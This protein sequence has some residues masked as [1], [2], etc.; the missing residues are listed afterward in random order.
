MGNIHSACQM[1]NHSHRNVRVFITEKAVEIDGFVTSEPGGD[2]KISPTLPEDKKSCFKT[3]INFIR[4]LAS[5]TREVPWEAQ[6]FVSIFVEDDDDQ[7]ICSRN[8]IHNMAM[9]APVTVL[10]YDV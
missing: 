8:I 6:H 1:S 10:L 9:S 4:V 2:D 7:D 3:D 5:Q